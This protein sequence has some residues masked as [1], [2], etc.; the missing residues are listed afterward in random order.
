MPPVPQRQKPTTTRSTTQTSVSANP[1]AAKIKRADELESSGIKCLLYGRSGTGK[2]T[3]WSTF[4]GPI[5]SVIISGGNQPG[6]LRSV[7]QENREK[8]S[9]INPSS[10]QEMK[11]IVDYAR[12]EFAG[13]TVVLDH[14]TGLQDLAL[15]EILGIDELPVQKGWGFATQQQYGAC[16]LQCKE[17]M[18]ALAN[19]PANVV[20]IA[21]EREF[22]PGED[23]GEV[24][25]PHVGAA[26][27]PALTNWLNG[28]VDYICQTYLRRKV[29]IKRTTVGTG[30][31][32]K[33]IETAVPAKGVEFCLRT[34]PDPIFMTKFRAPRSAAGLPEC[35]VNPTYEKLSAAIRG[36]EIPAD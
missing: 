6:E 29:E 31:K 14:A 2:T 15:K 34:A 26:L 16:T 8:I 17:V 32:A 23:G 11:D 10:I 25:I 36:E 12:T 35:I 30:D 27:S 33:V 20:V 9:A 24:A 13:G 1:I 28:T 7:A 21:H 19:L 22:K 18:R 5:L 4:P 3:L